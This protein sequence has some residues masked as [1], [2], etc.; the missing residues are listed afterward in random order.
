MANNNNSASIENLADIRIRGTV[1]MSRLINPEL[2]RGNYI[3]ELGLTNLQWEQPKNAEEQ[4]AIT[5]MQKRIKPAQGDYPETLWLKLPASSASGK[6]NFVKYYDKAKKTQVKTEK[7]IARGQQV[8]ALVHCF[9]LPGNKNVEDFD[10]VAGRLSGVMF[11]DVKKVQWYTPGN[12]GIQGFTTLDDSQAFTGFDANNQ[13]G[14]NQAPQGNFS[15]GGQGNFGGNGMNGQGQNNGF[16]GNGMNGQGQSNGFGGNGMNGQGQN[17]GF[18]GNDM[19]GQGQ[20]NGFGGNGMNGQGQNNG[21]GGN[22][23]QNQTNTQDNN[24]PFGGTQDQNNGSDVFGG[25]GADTKS[26]F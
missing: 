2:Y 16:G 20:N 8:T 9:V 19:N 7:D 14:N 5:N 25:S 1:A 26:P 3:Y 23:G 15:N 13:G 12:P 17:N 6:P 4:R 18:G 11:D 21:F 22:G 24:G 10:W